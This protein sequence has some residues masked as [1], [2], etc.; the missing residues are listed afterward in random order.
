LDKGQFKNGNGFLN[1]YD[2]SGRIVKRGN[3]VDGYPHGSWE[4]MA[5]GKMVAEIQFAHGVRE[6]LASKETIYW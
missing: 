3:M 5:E 6:G 4:L 1:V 2:R